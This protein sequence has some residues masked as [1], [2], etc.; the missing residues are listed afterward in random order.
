[1]NKNFPKAKFITFLIILLSFTY[2]DSIAQRGS[3]NRENDGINLELSENLSGIY[4][5]DPIGLQLAARLITL[6]GTIDQTTYVLGSND[7][8]SVK[9]ESVQPLFLRGVVVNPQG[10]IIIPLIGAVKVSGLTIVEAEEKLEEVL[11][12]QVKDPSITI[13]VDN[14]RPVIYHITGNV[15]HP[16][17]Y[18]S[19]PNSRI[20]QAIFSSITSG[21]RDITKITPNSSEFLGNS[22]FSFRSIKIYRANGSETD[23]DLIKYFRTGDLSSNPFIRDGDLISINRLNRETPKVSISGAVK[24]DFEFE[25]KKGDTPALVLEFGG[26]FEEVADTSKLFVYRRGVTGIEQLVLSPE[27]WDTFQLRPNDRVVAPFGD[28]FDAS[29][30]AWVYGEVNIPGN[31][32]VRSGETTALELLETAGG[33]TT[34]ALPA[35]AYLVRSGSLKNEIP[36]QFNADLMKRTSDQVVQGLEYLDAETNLSKNQVF[37]DLNDNSQLQSLRIFD[38]DRLYVPRDEE[39][40]FIFGQVNNPGYFGFSPNKTVTQY[41]QQAGGFALSADR[42][43]VFILKAGNATWFKVGETEL[44]SGDRIFV[45]REPVEELNAKRQY[46]IQRQQLKNQRIQLIMTGITTITGIITTYVAVRRL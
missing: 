14:P 2:S 26:G 33:L 8:L 39:T 34:E 24:A 3:D 27:E 22:N 41:I 9:V 10:D 32:P 5:N 6:E 45:D 20:D 11:K 7:L 36:N 23:A 16:G 19:S 42:E 17:K 12:G 30:S 4:Y 1:M 46:E 21:D 40:I 25:Y 13:S 35:A 15:P 43:R 38:G 18:I 31:F 37:I 28:D 44:S 29:A